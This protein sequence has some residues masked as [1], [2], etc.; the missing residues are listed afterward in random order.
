MQEN[1]GSNMQ[2]A[3]S[4][5]GNRTRRTETSL[6]QL[7]PHRARDHQCLRHTSGK[8]ETN[9]TWTTSQPRDSA[10]LSTTNAEGGTLL[11]GG[12]ALLDLV[13]VRGHAEQIAGGDLVDA[14]Q[15]RWARGDAASGAKRTGVGI[16]GK[17]WDRGRQ[18]GRWGGWT[19]ETL[20]LNNGAVR[21]TDFCMAQNAR[22]RNSPQNWP[23]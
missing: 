16:G 15:Q 10:P 5:V 9:G 19:G 4:G 17:G 23:K 8:N 18:K 14:A 11:L 6:C 21:V 7:G 12:D 2:E 13:D 20:H 3:Y 22:P 1:Y